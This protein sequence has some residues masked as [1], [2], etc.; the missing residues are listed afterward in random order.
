ML[1]FIA[2]ILADKNKKPGLKQKPAVFIE[3]VQGH[4]AVQVRNPGQERWTY[5]IDFT[6]KVNVYNNFGDILGTRPVIQSFDSYDH[7]VTWVAANITGATFEKDGA[8]DSSEAY[9]T[10][11]ANS[12]LFSA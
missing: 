11:T 1:R 12:A 9:S 5:V 2:N 4:W 8:R 3:F 7:A 10:S 6:K